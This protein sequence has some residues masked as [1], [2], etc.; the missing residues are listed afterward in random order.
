MDIQSANLYEYLFVENSEFKWRGDLITLQKL[1]KDELNLT[2]KWTSPGG[3]VKQFSCL[4]ATIKWYQGKKVLKI[5]GKNT[6]T[7]EQRLR[8]AIEI[9]RSK[10]TNIEASQLSNIKATHVQGDLSEPQNNTSVEELSEIPSLVNKTKASDPK[11]KVCNCDCIC[12]GEINTSDGKLYQHISTSASKL[13]AEI[14]QNVLEIDTLKAKQKDL[15]VKIHQQ[16]E[17][18]YKLNQE[19][20]VFKFKFES[21]ENLILRLQENNDRGLGINEINIS[22]VMAPISNVPLNKSN[23]S[24]IT[25]AKSDS[26][27]PLKSPVNLNVNTESL[28]D[29]IQ[30]GPEINVANTAGKT[31]SCNDVQPDN[32][33]VINTSSRNNGTPSSFKTPARLNKNNT[34][35]MIIEI[36]SSKQIPRNSHNDYLNKPKTLI[37]QS[38]KNQGSSSKSQTIP[39]KNGETPPKR[40]TPCPFLRRRGWCAKGNRCNFMH[41]K[42]VHHNY[43]TA[44]PYPFPQGDGFPPIGNFY[45]PRNGLYHETYNQV[46]PY[47]SPFLSHRRRPMTPVPLMDILVQPSPMPFPRHY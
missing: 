19:N 43:H 12:I 18:I 47:S 34:S 45:I 23:K 9:S 46:P 17:M 7:I 13:S 3:D 38:N 42:P 37:Q 11:T 32:S 27:S 44:T 1:V 26:L 29:S 10:Q 31:T 20:S 40:Y 2:G 41:P 14:S 36:P 4:S 6:Q 24:N 22:S 25:L 21:L 15:E 33:Q 39:L 30:R 35:P 5:L 16:E 28:S 8:A